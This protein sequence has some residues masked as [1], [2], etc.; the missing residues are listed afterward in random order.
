MRSLRRLC[1]ERRH[2][3][4]PRRDAAQMQFGTTTVAEA[5]PLDDNR[6]VR[7]APRLAACGLALSAFVLTAG[8]LL[9]D[10]IAADRHV[11]GSGPPWLYPFLVAAISAPAAVG[12]LIAT[13]RPRNPIGWVLVLGALSIAAVLA[14]QTYGLVALDAHPGSLPGGSWAALLASQ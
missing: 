8:G 10:R 11:P 12:A 6:R 14:A 7:I 9:L 2:I 13:R 4:N 1:Q 5:A 3:R